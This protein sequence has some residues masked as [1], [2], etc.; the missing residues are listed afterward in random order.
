[1]FNTC[2]KFGMMVTMIWSNVPKIEYD[3]TPLRIL[4][5][6]SIHVYILGFY[7]WRV[8]HSGYSTHNS[9]AILWT[10]T[11]PSFM[12]ALIRCNAAILIKHQAQMRLNHLCLA[13]HNV[14]ILGNQLGVIWAT[15]N[16]QLQKCLFFFIQ[17]E[18]F[19]KLTYRFHLF[20]VGAANF[21][22]SHWG[23]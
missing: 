6:C 8:L 3:L 23:R 22:L 7:R 4:T 14:S 1:M 17:M 11:G 21:L 15:I 16:L 9:Y 12:I 18:P 19:A 13:H 10:L 2:E 20:L 5:V